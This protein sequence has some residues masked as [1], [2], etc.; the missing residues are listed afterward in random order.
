M[1]QPFKRPLVLHYIAIA[2][3]VGLLF[4]DSGI[5][6]TLSDLRDDSDGNLIEWAHAPQPTTGKVE[7]ILVDG[8]TE[9]MLNLFESSYVSPDLQTAEDEA[10]LDAQRAKTS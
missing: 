3:P 4:E 9:E 1:S 10:W 6:D 2:L 7:G 5:M 8:E